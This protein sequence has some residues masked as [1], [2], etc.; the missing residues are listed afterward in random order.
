VLEQAAQDVG[1]R[2]SG[3]YVGGAGQPLLEEAVQLGA[4]LAEGAP[5]RDSQRAHARHRQQRDQDE[6]ADRRAGAPVLAPEHRQDAEQKQ[7]VAE[8]LDH[9]L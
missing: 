3:A 7:D 9:E 6:A 4:R 5:V 1:R 8:D 2:A